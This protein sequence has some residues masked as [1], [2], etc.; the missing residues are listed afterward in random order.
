MPLKFEGVLLSGF[1]VGLNEHLVYIGGREHGV[2]CVFTTKKT[3]Q[4]VKLSQL[5]HIRGRYLCLCAIHRM[6]PFRWSLKSSQ[7][8]LHPQHTIAAGTRLL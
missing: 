2:P 4:Q 7:G 6:K 8:V 5:S 3:L 1:G